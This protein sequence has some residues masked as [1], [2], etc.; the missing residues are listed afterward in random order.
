MNT[1]ARWRNR[2]QG[3]IHSF[4]QQ[5]HSARAARAR[6]SDTRDTSQALHHKPLFLKWLSAPCPIPSLFVSLLACRPFSVTS[7]RM[8]PGALFF[9]CDELSEVGCTT[10]RVSSSFSSCFSLSLYFYCFVSWFSL[11]VARQYL[12]FF[13]ERNRLYLP[14]LLWGPTC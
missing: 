13:G 11:R 3:F 1:V 2:T 4:I 6:T 8:G 12:V 14:A 7:F 9:F 10:S 5:C